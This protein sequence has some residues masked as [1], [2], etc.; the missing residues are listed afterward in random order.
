MDSRKDLTECLLLMT[1]RTRHLNSNSGPGG[2]RRRN[3]GLCF[4][5]FGNLCSPAISLAF[6]AILTGSAQAHDHGGGGGDQSHQQ[7]FHRHDYDHHYYYR[8]PGIRGTRESTTRTIGTLQLRSKGRKRRSKC[9]P[10][11]LLSR[12]VASAPHLIVTLLFKRFAQQ[13]SSSRII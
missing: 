12:R 11:S 3:P 13:K 7:S 2:P 6:A 8:D 4:K 1:R 10:I 9:R 5:W